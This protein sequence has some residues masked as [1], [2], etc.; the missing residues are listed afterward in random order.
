MSQESLGV[1]CPYLTGETF[2]VNLFS[3]SSGFPQRALT[4]SIALL[5]VVMNLHQFLA[6]LVKLRYLQRVREAQ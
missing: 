3:M 1:V 2:L 5:S 4:I 6:N